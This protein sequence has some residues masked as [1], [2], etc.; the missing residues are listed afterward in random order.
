MALD[1]G[2]RLIAG[3]D[4]APVLQGWAIVEN[5]MMYPDGTFD[6]LGPGRHLN[7]A[8]F[9]EHGFVDGDLQDAILQE[10][11][12]SHLAGFGAPLELQR[13]VFEPHAGDI[14]LFG[15]FTTP[16]QQCSGLD[17]RSPPYRTTRR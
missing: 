2:Y 3:V 15:T 1:M 11:G 9:L 5:T 10:S 7:V 12:I 13:L 8:F 17:I 4:D 14:G 16:G 6:L